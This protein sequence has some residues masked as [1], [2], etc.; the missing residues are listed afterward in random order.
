MNVESIKNIS[1]IP[2]AIDYRR[3]YRG[4]AVIRVV[5]NT[6]P[7]CPIEFVLEQ[8]PLG[9]Y[10]VSVTFLEPMDFPIV[11]AIRQLKAFIT[12]LDRGGG[13]P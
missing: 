1:R 13:L 2:L 5:G 8:S 4:V 3:M 12:D 6:T 11:P 9:G 10:D 7:S